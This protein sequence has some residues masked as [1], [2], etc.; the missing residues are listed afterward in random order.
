[1]RSLD[2]L[3]GED[4]WKDFRELAVYFAI[5][6]NMMDRSFLDLKDA[7]SFYCRIQSK[8]SL[9]NSS[10]E[11]HLYFLQNDYAGLIKIGKSFNVGEK[12]NQ[13]E[14]AYPGKNKLLAY[15]YDC[16]KHKSDLHTIFSEF[17][18]SG[19]WFSA[20]K[21]LIKLTDSVSTHGPRAIEYFLNNRGDVL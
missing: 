12:F 3:S 13:L 19:E 7:I 15:A 1:M 6:D 4:S 21:L 2:E 14:K 8:H 9:P 5:Q 17:K 16:G 18:E 10:K 20:N 11:S